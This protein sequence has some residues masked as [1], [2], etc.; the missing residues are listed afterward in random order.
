MSESPNQ[1]QSE[2]HKTYYQEHKEKYH[3]N[4]RSYISKHYSKEVCDIVF[5]IDCADKV[6]CAKFL[7][8]AIKIKLDNPELIAQ[9]LNK[10]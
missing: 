6:N 5:D 9:L 1:K 3:N 2:Y 4:K 8:T 10:L 7:K